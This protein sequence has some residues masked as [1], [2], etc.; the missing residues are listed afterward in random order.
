MAAAPSLLVRGTDTIKIN[1]NN[2]N[3][4]STG[5]G[6]LTISVTGTGSNTVYGNITGAV[7]VSGG[8]TLNLSGSLNGSATIGANSILQLGGTATGIVVSK[9]AFL[10]WKMAEGRVTLKSAAAAWKLSAPVGLIS[11]RRSA[12]IFR[13]LLTAVP[14]PRKSTAAVSCSLECLVTAA[15]ASSA[16][17]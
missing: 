11:A 5:T 14:L 8:G 16:I 2:S 1:G 7:S 13:S 6:A 15:A 3:T 10:K 9:T 17:R 12:A 4:I